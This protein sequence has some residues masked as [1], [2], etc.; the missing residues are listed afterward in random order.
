MGNREALRAKRR[1]RWIAWIKGG[2]V[3]ATKLYPWQVELVRL[4]SRR[5]IPVG[6]PPSLKLWD[7]WAVQPQHHCFW[8]QSV[9]NPSQD[10]CFICRDRRPHEAD[11]P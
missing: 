7:T 1:R 8:R 11:T 4:L 3:T 10:F 2:G 6:D 9:M 5:P